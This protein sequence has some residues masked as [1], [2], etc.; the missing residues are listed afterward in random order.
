MENPIAPGAGRPDTTEKALRLLPAAVIAVGGRAQPDAVCPLLEEAGFAVRHQASVPCEAEAVQA[1][2][3]YC[4]DELSAALVL[5]L[6]GTSLAPGD[7]VPEAT[8]AVLDRE[9]RGLPEAMRMAGMAFTPR[10][11]L[12]RGVAGVRGRTLIVNLPGSAKAAGE[13]LSAV[14]E[15]LRHGAEMLQK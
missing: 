12:S 9:V 10:A 8:L 2:L 4:A 6:G 3:M 14:L 7:I 15:P 13:D 11:C 1:A 5:T